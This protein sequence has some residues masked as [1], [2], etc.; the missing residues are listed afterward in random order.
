M[1]SQQGGES[2]DC[3]T[4]HLLAAS[5]QAYAEAEERLKLAE[6]F[7]HLC[8]LTKLRC[9]T[10]S[11]PEPLHVHLVTQAAGCVQPRED[12]A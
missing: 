10:R 9:G 3:L 11:V 1:G 2:R 4:V 6:S 5:T 12:H 8:V 7:H